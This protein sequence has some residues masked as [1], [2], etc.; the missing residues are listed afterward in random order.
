MFYL[1]NITC[2]QFTSTSA[3]SEGF[4]HQKLTALK[5]FLNFYFSCSCELLTMSAVP[6]GA[7]LAAKIRQNEKKPSDP[8]AFYENNMELNPLQYNSKMMNSIW[9]LY[10]RYS[11]HNLKKNIDKNVTFNTVNQQIQSVGSTAGGAKC[12][13]SPQVFTNP[14]DKLRSTF[15]N[16]H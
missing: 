6:Q 8:G 7:F 3:P 13:N 11:V 12:T 16:P 15:G 2:M 10:N 14:W 9:G 1:V 4:F 5:L